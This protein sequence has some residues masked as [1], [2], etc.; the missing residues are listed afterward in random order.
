MY[1]SVPSSTRSSGL[2][3][4]PTFP[5]VLP[6]YLFILQY[7]IVNCHETDSK[8]LDSDETEKTL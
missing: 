2:S 8:L 3:L 5:S 1:S 4:I 6:L 7:T